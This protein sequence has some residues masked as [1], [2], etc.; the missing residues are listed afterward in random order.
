MDPVLHFE[1]RYT[2]ELR[3]VVCH[4]H[5]TFAACVTCNVQ[6]IHTDGLASAFRQ[7]VVANLGAAMEE[8]VPRLAETV[9]AEL[10]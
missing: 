6:I 8:A 2:N 7:E 1:R 5:Q 9:S 3:H 10:C 4:Q